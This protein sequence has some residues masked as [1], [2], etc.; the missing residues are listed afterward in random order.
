MIQ[1]GVV[2]TEKSQIASANE[3]TRLSVCIC[4]VMGY[5]G[6][7]LLAEM[8]HLQGALGGA[9]SDVCSCSKLAD[10]LVSVLVQNIV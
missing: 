8:Q 6:G 1:E 4:E 3:L 2:T 9:D 7:R 5:P 10:G